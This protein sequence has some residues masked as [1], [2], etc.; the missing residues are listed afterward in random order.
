MKTETTQ[1]FTSTETGPRGGKQTWYTVRLP[2]QDH[3]SS[4]ALWARSKRK[5]RESVHAANVSYGV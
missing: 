4:R 3:P 1:Y 5:A 2:G